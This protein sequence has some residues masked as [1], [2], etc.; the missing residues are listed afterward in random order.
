LEFTIAG[1]E[2]VPRSSEPR[3][4]AH[5]S[6]PDNPKAR[7]G[8]ACLAQCFKI[9]ESGS[10]QEK[11][12]TYPALSPLRRRARIGMRIKNAFRKRPLILPANPHPLNVPHYQIFP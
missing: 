7:H 5:Q 3:G 2:M 1:M 6:V 4:K 9:F 10:W 8:G 12:L 11:R